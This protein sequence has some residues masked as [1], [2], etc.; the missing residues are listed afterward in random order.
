MKKLRELLASLSRSLGIQ[1]RLRDRAVRRMKAR[2]DAQNKAERQAKAAREAADRLR[3]EAHR[4]GVEDPARARRLRR[5]ERKGA[6]AGRYDVKAE[7]EKT[8]AVFWRG[9]A[10]TL[11]KRIA[12]LDDSIETVKKQIA[13][14][15]PTVDGNH[16]KGGGEFERWL[17]CLNTMALNCSRGLPGGRRN[18]Y[19][20]SGSWNLDHPIHPG[21][22]YGERSDCSQTM[23]AAIKACGFPDING[24]D[25][26]GG[27]TGSML[28]AAGRWREVSLE[29]ML[30]ARRPA[31]IVYG[32][33]PGHH[34]EGW[35]PSLD[36]DGDFIDAMRTVGHG[37]APVD[38]GT[39]HTFGSGETERYFILAAE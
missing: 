26:R 31:V 27:F 22:A 29:H 21:E 33:D 38:P 28:R 5:A 24:E 9:R 23:T 14:L 32:R 17:V 2:H 1:E 10:R 6:K 7:R 16:V 15:G 8:R 3:R 34:T 18:F 20:M 25:F 37:S 39:V 19:S 12:K 11:S 35:C 4:L 36:D 30:R 13:K